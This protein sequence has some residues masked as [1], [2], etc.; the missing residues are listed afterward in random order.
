MDG[1][2]KGRLRERWQ[3]RQEMRENGVEMPVWHLPTRGE[4]AEFQDLRNLTDIIETW[5]PDQLDSYG[6]GPNGMQP[7]HAVDK[8][9]A[10]DLLWREQ[11][12]GLSERGVAEYAHL[13]NRWR[14]EYVPELKAEFGA[15][16]YESIP[17]LLDR[18]RQEQG[19]SAGQEET[20]Q[21]DLYQPNQL[22]LDLGQTTDALTETR[23]AHYAQQEVEQAAANEAAWERVQGD[24]ELSP[25]Q[26]FELAEQT[27]RERHAV[28][29]E[30]LGLSHLIH[31]P[32]TEEEAWR[33][34]ER[35]FDENQIRLAAREA[36][37]AE[38]AMHRLGARTIPEQIK[39]RAAAI[40]AASDRMPTPKQR[41]TDSYGY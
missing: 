9:R 37:S 32:L 31:A 19:L 26:A 6:V 28:E 34:V 16:G 30:N 8:V 17:D 21:L 11:H 25:E 24:R 15:R 35:R 39:T 1:E 3:Y 38:L 12:T 13:L 29:L 41:E 36:S 23:H 33:A 14:M 2:E 40:H 4:Y 22:P 20:T 7:L 5:R 10:E 18:V 27:G